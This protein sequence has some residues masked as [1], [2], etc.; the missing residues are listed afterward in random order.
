M[1]RRWLKSSA[2]H[3]EIFTDQE[4]DNFEALYNGIKKSKY[5]GDKEYYLQKYWDEIYAFAKRRLNDSG[6]RMFILNEME[7]WEFGNPPKPTT[8]DR[9]VAKYTKE[10]YDYGIKSSF[11]KRRIAQSNIL[12]DSE[13]DGW[14]DEVR[15]NL[16]DAFRSSE[17]LAYEVRNCIRGAY[18]GCKTIEELAE[19]VRSVGNLYLEAADY[20]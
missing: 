4:A 9:L 13:D 19:K 11:G 18:T 17:R 6:N 16:E 12:L 3:Y 8:V 15:D 7:A 2:T 1:K 5:V 20:L 10:P 14:G